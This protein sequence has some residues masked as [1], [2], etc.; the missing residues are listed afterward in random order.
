MHKYCGYSRLSG[1]INFRIFFKEVTIRGGCTLLVVKLTPE[2]HWKAGKIC[3]VSE[4]LVIL[5]V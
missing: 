5:F 2:G 3:A 4:L 1:S